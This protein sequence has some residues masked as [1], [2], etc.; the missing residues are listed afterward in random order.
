MKKVPVQ[1][2]PIKAD[3]PTMKSQTRAGILREDMENHDL[4][5]SGQTLHLHEPKCCKK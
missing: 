3:V 5:K 2:G 4:R 1:K